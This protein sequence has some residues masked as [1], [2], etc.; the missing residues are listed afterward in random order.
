MRKEPSKQE[1]SRM[2]EE[3]TPKHNSLKNCMKAFFTGGLFCV[4]GEGIKQ[5]L[6]NQ[7]GLDKNDALLYV[8]ISLVLLSV[9]LTG[10]NLYGKITKFGGAGGLV[11]ITGFANSMA[12]SAMDSRKAF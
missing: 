6:M 12:A 10:W 3:M 2:V 7:W 9:L 11:P 1:Y 4:L 5:M 8:T